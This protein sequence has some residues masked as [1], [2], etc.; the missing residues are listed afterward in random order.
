[1][2]AEHGLHDEPRLLFERMKSES[3][4]RL[5]SLDAVC[6]FHL[7]RVQSPITFKN[8]ILPLRDQLN[9]IWDSLRSIAGNRISDSHWTN[10]R[11]KM[12]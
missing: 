7:S 9:S 10:F 5:L 8:G 12:G 6:W 2:Q 4:L 3:N 1:M 11:N